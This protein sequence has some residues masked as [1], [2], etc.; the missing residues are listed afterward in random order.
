MNPAFSIIGSY[1]TLLEPVFSATDRL[2]AGTVVE[3]F[4]TWGLHC[5]DTAEYDIRAIDGTTIL[6]VHHRKL[7]WDGQL[8]QQHVTAADANRLDR[9]QSAAPQS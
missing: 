6:R 7:E 2:E 1:Y 9:A 3:V 8:A 4:G 5:D